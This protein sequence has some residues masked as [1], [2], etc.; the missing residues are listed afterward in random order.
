MAT[1]SSTGITVSPIPRTLASNV[2]GRSEFLDELGHQESVPILD[3]LRESDLGK[4]ATNERNGSHEAPMEDASRASC[5]AN[6]ARLQN[7]ERHDRGVEHV[8]QFMRQEPCALAPTR[9]FSIE[10]RLILF[11]SELG[12]GARDG[13]VEASV[14]C[15]KVIGADGRVLFHCEIGDGLTHVAVIVNDL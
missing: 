1:P 14:Q 13:V 6:I 9:G 4:R 8:A 11:A 2:C 5:D 3:A 15:A 7:L 10:G 12:N